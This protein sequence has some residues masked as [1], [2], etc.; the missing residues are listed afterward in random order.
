[1]QSLEDKSSPEGKVEHD[2]RLALRQEGFILS[3]TLIN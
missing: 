3:I 2:D 1:M